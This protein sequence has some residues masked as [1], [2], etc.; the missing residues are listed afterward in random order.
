V[1]SVS[2]TVLYAAEIP[3]NA[4]LEVSSHSGRVEIRVPRDVSARFEVSTF[5]GSIDS[6]IGG[7]VEKS[8][9]FVPGAELE[10]TLGDGDA[11]VEVTSFS[12][13]VRLVRG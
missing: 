7:D 8:G 12:G 2:G 9:G 1:S 4:H 10:V 11:L 6:D 5:S 13:A 3:A